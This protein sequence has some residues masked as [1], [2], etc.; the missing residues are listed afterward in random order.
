[1][2]LCISS[3]LILFAIRTCWSAAFRTSWD[4]VRLATSVSP[5]P[6]LS[7]CNYTFPTVIT[8][9]PAQWSSMLLHTP[10]VSHMVR[11][12]FTE[13]FDNSRKSRLGGTRWRRWLRH[14]AAS[15]KVVGSICDRAIRIFHWLNPSGR[16]VV[17]ESTQ[18]LTKMST[19][20]ISWEVKAASA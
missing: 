1:M 14:C 9:H 4:E 19:R 12:W 16:T 10:T 18:P 3:N 5:S 6:G 15:R 11:K 2:K 8:N 20:D 17:L 7:A 13:V